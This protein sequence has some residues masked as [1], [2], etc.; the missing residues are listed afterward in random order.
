MEG[1]GNSSAWKPEAGIF[2]IANTLKLPACTLNTSLPNRYALD[3]QILFLHG[4]STQQ[5]QTLRGDESFTMSA[6]PLFDYL[7][8]TPSDTMARKLWH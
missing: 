1:K 2:H 6:C 3:L 8:E 4:Q 5:R 7:P